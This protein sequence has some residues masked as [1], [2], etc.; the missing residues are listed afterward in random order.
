MTM[1]ANAK[2]YMLSEI[3]D[4]KAA[5][6]LAEGLLAQRGSELMIDA[7]RVERLGAQSLQILLS[8]V[9]TWHADGVSIEFID[10]SEPFIQGLELFGIDPERFFNGGHAPG[11]V[12]IG[13]N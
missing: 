11:L 10:P 13:L 5:L 3:L 6:P 9:S 12:D 4:I 1:L 8:A 2:T 7:S